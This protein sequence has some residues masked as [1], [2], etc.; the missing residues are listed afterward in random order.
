MLPR[1]LALEQART[2]RAGAGLLCCGSVGFLLFSFSS[3]SQDDGRG[4]A[5]LQLGAPLPA[6]PLPLAPGIRCALAREGASRPQMRFQRRTQ[7][8]NQ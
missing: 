8:A 3:P 2:R 4:T 1:L 6:R 5:E 7:K